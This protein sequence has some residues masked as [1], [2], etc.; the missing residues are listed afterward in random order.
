ML[1]SMVYDAATTAV[2]FQL[3]TSEMVTTDIK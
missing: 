2:F 1:D 3:E